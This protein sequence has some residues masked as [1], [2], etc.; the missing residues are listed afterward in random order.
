MVSNSETKLSLGIWLKS[1]SPF[2]FTY[3]MALHPQVGEPE[4]VSKSET[5]SVL[6]MASILVPLPWHSLAPAC[7]PSFHH[8]EPLLL[9][10]MG[11]DS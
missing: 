10:L 4:L 7:L 2:I 8:L 3:K 6:L 11:V 9:P 1:N 5:K